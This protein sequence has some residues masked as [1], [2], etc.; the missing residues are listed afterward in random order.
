[1]ITRGLALLLVVALAG[2]TRSVDNA[3]PQAEPPAAPITAGQVGDLLSEKAKPDDDPN[4]FA[5]VEPEQC[6]GLA[7]EVDAPFIFDTTPAA[8]DGG[9]WFADDAESSISVQEITGV[10]PADFDPRAAVDVVKS[11]IESCQQDTLTATAM[12]GEVV[13]FRLL[14][15]QD[16]GSPEIVLWS[17]T[18][19]WACDNAFVAAHN[20]AV[21]LTTCGPKG[22]YDVLSLAQDGLKRIEKLANMA[23]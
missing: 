21:E 5:T 6:A 18:G 15:Q 8:H 16:S 22:G 19:G 2:C 7:Q 11:T 17:V 9:H 12:D 1:M 3:R 10:Y 23:A 4:L 14:P 13:D 20:A